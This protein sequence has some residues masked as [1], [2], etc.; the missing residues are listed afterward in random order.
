MMGRCHDLGE[1]TA[2]TIVD[3]VEP[4]RGHHTRGSPRRLLYA[5]VKADIAELNGLRERITV[6]TWQADQQQHVADLSEI[7]AR[8]MTRIEDDLDKTL[9]RVA[10]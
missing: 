10:R 3:H 5:V 4:H 9:A 6:G 8:M 1:V 7:R 2:A